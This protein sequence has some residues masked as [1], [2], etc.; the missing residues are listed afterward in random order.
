MI[1]ETRKGPVHARL[2]QDGD[3]FEELTALLHRS[4]SVLAKLGLRY[5]ATHQDVETTRDRCLSGETYLGLHEGT[6]VSTVTLRPPG[7]ADSGYYGNPGVASFGQFGVDLPFQKSGL[8]AGMM[9]LIEDRARE[10]GAAELA[11]DT[12]Q[13]AKHLVKWYESMGYRIVEEADWRPTTNY[14]SWILSKYLVAKSD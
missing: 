2:L 6:I 3:S 1:I 9:R 13:P 12:A 10:L 4:Y 7:G 14:K 5:L 8:G 11:C